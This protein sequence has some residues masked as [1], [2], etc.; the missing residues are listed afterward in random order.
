MKRVALYVRVSTEEQDLEHQEHDLRAEAERRRWEVVA[1]FAEKAS[2]ANVH[3]R[4]GHGSELGKLMHDAKLNRFD[5]V[6]VWSISRVG[7]NLLEV[8]GVAQELFDAGVGVASFREPAVDTT[9]PMGRLVLQIGGAFAEFERAELIART[10][11]GLAGARRRGKRLG[12]PPKELDPGQVAFIVRNNG[13]SFAARSF[14]VSRDTIRKVLRK[15]P[16]APAG[17][18]SG[19]E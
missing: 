2:G 19:T 6:L 8:L 10:K 7:R 15:A 3:R 11:S 1:V 13:V 12:R 17:E 16:P 14:G 4:R 5:A 9:T 18:K